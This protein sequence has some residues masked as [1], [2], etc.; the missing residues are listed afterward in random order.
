MC[1]YNTRRTHAHTHGNV[2]THAHTR[3]IVSLSV[4]L[5]PKNMPPTLLNRSGTVAT[6]IPLPEKLLSDH[7]GKYRIK[8]FT[9]YVCR[10]FFSAYMDKKLYH[11]MIEY[12]IILSFNIGC[13]NM[14]TLT[15]LRDILFRLQLSIDSVEKRRCKVRQMPDDD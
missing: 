5:Y 13:N 14:D 6:I 3:G 1:R 2:Y 7:S 4:G 12:Y 10:K 8:N 11:C 9:C 15:R